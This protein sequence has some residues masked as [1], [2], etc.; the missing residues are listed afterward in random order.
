MS[1]A[2]TPVASLGISSWHSFSLLARSMSIRVRLVQS[3][4]LKL[5]ELAVYKS[6]GSGRMGGLVGAVWGGISDI[7]MSIGWWEGTWCS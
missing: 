7:V 4:S 1:C 5:D 3:F 2:S 6:G